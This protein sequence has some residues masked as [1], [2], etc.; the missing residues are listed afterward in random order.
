[1]R[2]AMTV[3]RGLPHPARTAV[4]CLDQI[5]MG[6]AKPLEGVLRLTHPHLN[7]L[8]SRERKF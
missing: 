4:L 7:P 1:M 3:W 5:D 8:P 2:L 6:N